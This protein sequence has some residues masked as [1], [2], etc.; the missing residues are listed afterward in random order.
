MILQD[1]GNIK[2]IQKFLSNNW[3]KNHIISKEIKILNW[4]HYNKFEKKYNFVLE[5]KKYL[6]FFRHN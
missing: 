5:K 2:L 4:L 3:Q 1:K 6:R